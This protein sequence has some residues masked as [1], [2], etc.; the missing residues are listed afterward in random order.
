MT[1]HTDPARFI[2]AT[3]DLDDNG[4]KADIGGWDLER[5]RKNPVVLFNHQR[6]HP[7]IGRADRVDI[8]GN[9]MLASI[10]FAPSKFGQAIADLV[11]QNFIR[12]AS[13]GWAP[14]AGAW[15]WLRNANGFPTGIHSHKQ[16]LREISIVGLPANPETLKQALLETSWDGALITSADDWLDTI[17]G[18]VPTQPQPS[19]PSSTY[20]EDLPDATIMRQLQAFNS[21]LRGN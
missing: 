20:P 8:I 18:A 3:S 1:T 21:K 9:Q 17:M 13:P 12:G 16:E 2:V 10:E 11:T 15:E 4:N 14:T 5:F 6:N 7:P 19:L